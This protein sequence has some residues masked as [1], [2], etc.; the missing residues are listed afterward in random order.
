MGEWKKEERKCEINGR[1]KYAFRFARCNINFCFVCCFF[2]FFLLQQHFPFIINTVLYMDL[3][4]DAWARAHDDRR[5]HGGLLAS[6]VCNDQNDV[7]CWN[8]CAEWKKKKRNKTSVHFILEAVLSRGEFQTVCDRHPCFCIE[9]C[10]IRTRSR[11]QILSTFQCLPISHIHIYEVSGARAAFLL[12]D[13]SFFRI[14]IFTSY[15]HTT[16][17]ISI[18][19]KSRRLKERERQNVHESVNY[20]VDQPLLKQRNGNNLRWL[21][22]GECT[23]A[24]TAATAPNTK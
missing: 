15:A 14:L 8:V 11:T 4:L 9:R 13:Y 23:G 19:R 3:R 22:L 18:M 7:P 20:T 24:A 16:D 6:G 1:L 5:D 12:I 17:V 2:F 10:R 21:L